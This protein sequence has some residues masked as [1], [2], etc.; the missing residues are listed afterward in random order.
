MRRSATLLFCTFLS[1]AVTGCGY[2]FKPAPE[3]APRESVFG[4]GG[5]VLGPGAPKSQADGPR[6]GIMVNANLW[7]ATLEVFANYRMLQADP[8][9]GTILYDWTPAPDTPNE[10]FR[11]NVVIRGEALTAENIQITAFRQVL[12]ADRKTWQDAAVA[13]Q[14]ARGL[15][16]AV[17]TKASAARTTNY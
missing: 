17:L 2:Q 13:P 12:D 14:F 7:K 11:F 1:V 16:D 4:E 15:E 9:G 8:Y 3:R 5:I 6:S 10:R